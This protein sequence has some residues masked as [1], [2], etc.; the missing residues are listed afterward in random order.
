MTIAL[1]I[2]ETLINYLI[3]GPYQHPQYQKPKYSKEK[4]TLFLHHKSLPSPLPPLVLKKLLTPLTTPRPQ[5]LHDHNRHVS[6]E[7]ATFNGFSGAFVTSALG[8]G[9]EVLFSPALTISA[10]VVMSTGFS[11]SVAFAGPGVVITVGGGVI[12]PSASS[13]DA[14]SSVLS[15]CGSS[16]ESASESS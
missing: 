3:P 2:Y 7:S 14:S 11:C 1:H 15:S 13:A 5:I 9:I 12:V 16:A 6:T 4:S 8:G 10:A